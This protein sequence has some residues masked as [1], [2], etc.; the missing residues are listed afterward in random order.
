MRAAR[1]EI[2]KG[3]NEGGGTNCYDPT[4]HVAD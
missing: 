1:A 2:R 4:G 3:T